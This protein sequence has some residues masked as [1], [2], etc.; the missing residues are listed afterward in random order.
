MRQ[1]MSSDIF[2]QGSNFL[3]DTDLAEND[4][5]DLMVLQMG[6]DMI[7]KRT[8]N[9]KQVKNNGK[10]HRAGDW[11]CL[12]CNNLNYSFRDVCNRCHILSKK[13]NLL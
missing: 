13:Q 11:V 10:N 3:S 2:T 9:K 8:K 1:Q 5:S 4:Y 12:L 7:P 6:Q